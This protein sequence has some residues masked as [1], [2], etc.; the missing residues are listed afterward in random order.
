VKDSAGLPMYVPS[1]SKTT[2]TLAP[3]EA[4]AV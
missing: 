1:A 2:I 3:F 4:G